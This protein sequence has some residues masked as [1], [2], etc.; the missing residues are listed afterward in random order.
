[1]R[2]VESTEVTAASATATVRLDRTASVKMQLVPVAFESEIEVNSVVPIIDTTRTNTGEVFDETYLRN[3]TIG[4]DN[5][6]RYT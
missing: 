1:M 4:S 2:P 6:R 3:A 5:I